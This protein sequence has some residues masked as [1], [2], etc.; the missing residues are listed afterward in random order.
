MA[1]RH[2]GPRLW[3]A[4]ALMA[5]LSVVLFWVVGFLPW[6][7][8]GF[9][10][11]AVQATGP[12]AGLA[13]VRLAVPLVAVRLPELVASALVGGVLAGIVP[14]AFPRL[15]RL[16]GVVVTGSIVLA[17]TS[18]VL[19]AS[20]RSLEQHASSEFAADGRVV[21]GLMLVVVCAAMLGLAVGL[22]ATVRHGLVAVAAGLVAA[23]LPV[24]LAAFPVPVPGPAGQALAAVALAVGLVVSVH[25]TAWSALLWPV[26]LALAWLGAPLA[27][28]AGY[29]AD[30]LRPG[31]EAG[32]GS[33]L[34]GALDAA[35]AKLDPGAQPW[36]PWALAVVLAVAVL[37]VARVRRG[38]RGPGEPQAEVSVPRPRGPG[39]SVSPAR[40]KH[41]AT[42]RG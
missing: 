25:R 34:R 3:G 22:A 8:G 15:S 4:V 16:L 9:V 38:R 29:G 42:R 21:Q 6:V 31:G 26:G 28:G 10:L 32:A 14:I 19:A 37:P 17:T 41:T 23:V 24:W 27:A 7:L 40:G 30:R 20:R 11:P 18:T 35:T 12:A 1:D 2:R 13:G 5:L 36:W 33:L 39:T